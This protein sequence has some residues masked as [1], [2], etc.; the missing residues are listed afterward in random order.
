[1]GSFDGEFYNGN[2][3]WWT[4]A[5]QDYLGEQ[6]FCVTRRLH[7]ELPRDDCILFVS[8]L[9][10]RSKRSILFM[11]MLASKWCSQ[12]IKAQNHNQLSFQF[13]LDNQTFVVLV[14]SLL[15]PQWWYWSVQ[16][17]RW[18]CIQ[19]RSY[20]MTAVFPLL[21]HHLLNTLYFPAGLLLS[22]G[23]MLN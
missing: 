16:K 14:M 21:G 13:S 11:L 3:S 12:L 6:S 19:C 20:I 22:V 1:M 10:S 18:R 9:E 17:F 8:C 2:G 4:T 23:Q 5:V 15:L 7:R